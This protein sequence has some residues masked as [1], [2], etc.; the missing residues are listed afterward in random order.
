MFSHQRSASLPVACFGPAVPF[1]GAFG[2]DA[3]GQTVAGPFQ[4]DR[5]ADRERSRIRGISQGW[6][7][8]AATAI[9]CCALRRRRMPRIATALAAGA[10]L[11]GMSRSHVRKKLV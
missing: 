6:Q 8:K 2:L 11:A 1:F 9:V 10:P 5:G 4:A 7:G 3:T